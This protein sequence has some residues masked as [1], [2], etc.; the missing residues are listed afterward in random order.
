MSGAIDEIAGTGTE[1][2]NV[3]GSETTFPGLTT[4]ILKSCAI[5][6]SPAVKSTCSSVALTN[7]V[8]RGESST[9]TTDDDVKFVPLMTSVNGV[10]PMFAFGG[11]SDV[12]DGASAAVIVSV[13]G[14]EVFVP[15][16]RVTVMS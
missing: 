12:I 13:S 1:T 2:D 7:V 9:V 4:S 5:A 15:S 16:L 14:A 10:S 8:V 11:V 6:R 3:A